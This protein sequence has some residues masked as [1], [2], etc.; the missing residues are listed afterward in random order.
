MKNAG[1]A[2]NMWLWGGYGVPVNV[3]HVDIAAK[4]PE[5]GSPSSMHLEL[6]KR[7]MVTRSLEI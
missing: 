6:Y 1:N 7:R 3:D 4:A 5:P 2:G